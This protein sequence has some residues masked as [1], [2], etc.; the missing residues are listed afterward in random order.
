MPV[1]PL[2]DMPTD[3]KNFLLDIQADI[4]KKKKV[5]QFSLES[6]IYHIIREYKKS[7]EKK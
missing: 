5:G 3:V 6:T 7:K 4:K 1:L 2:K